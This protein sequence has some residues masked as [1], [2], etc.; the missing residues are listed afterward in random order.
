MDSNVLSVMH[1]LS[2]VV[3]WTLKGVIFK[4]FLKVWQGPDRRQM[5]PCWPGQLPPTAAG[6]NLGFAELVAIRISCQNAA[7]KVVFFPNAV[8]T[9]CGQHEHSLAKKK[10]TK[11]RG[12]LVS[13]ASPF[14]LC[15]TAFLYWP[16]LKHEHAAGGHNKCPTPDSDASRGHGNSL[17]RSVRP[18]HSRAGGLKKKLLRSS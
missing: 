8:C 14:A 15:Q 7:W 11:N 13:A 1:G 3:K 9:N 17:I 2:T 12:G 6:P 4:H 10:T 16:T 18:Q 5:L